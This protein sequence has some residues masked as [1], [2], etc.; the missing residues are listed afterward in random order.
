M[1]LQLVGIALVVAATVALTA[2]T[3][4]ATSTT[5]TGTPDGPTIMAVYPDVNWYPPCSISPIEIGGDLYYPLPYGAPPVDE[6]LYPILVGPA[7]DNLRE[8][9]PLAV[10]VVSVVSRPDAPGPGDDIGWVTVY[11][12]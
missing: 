9:P 8:G 4:V 6:S 2:C 11:S 1:R 7:G 5:P 3:S 10:K 12:D